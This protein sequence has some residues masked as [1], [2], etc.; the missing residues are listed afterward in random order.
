M[1]LNR[2]FCGANFAICILIIENKIEDQF[3]NKTQS[4]RELELPRQILR[5]LDNESGVLLFTKRDNNRTSSLD[6]LSFSRP[7]SRSLQ[8]KNGKISPLQ[9]F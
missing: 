9:T 4:D 3:D 6:F 2:S 5:C 1:R 8:E 7:S